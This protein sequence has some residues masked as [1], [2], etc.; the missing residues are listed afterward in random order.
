MQG[1]KEREREQK[2]KTLLSKKRSVFKKS[3]TGPAL[4]EM[5][6]KQQ[7]IGVLLERF[8]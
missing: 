4:L 6:G 2:R 3:L 8:I 7:T 5:S 1:K